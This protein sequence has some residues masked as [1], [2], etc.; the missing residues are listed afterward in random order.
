MLPIILFG[1]KETLPIVGEGEKTEDSPFQLCQK[2]VDALLTLKRSKYDDGAT[3]MA[4]SL[5]MDREFNNLK[6]IFSQFVGINVADFSHCMVWKKTKAMVWKDDIV[7][8]IDS[9]EW[10]T[11]LS[12]D[13]SAHYVVLYGAA[14]NIVNSCVFVA[15]QSS[16]DISE[17]DK[18]CLEFFKKFDFSEQ[19]HST[20]P[21][22]DSMKHYLRFALIFPAIEYQVQREEWK[23][24][25]EER[26]KAEQNLPKR[27][28]D[29]LKDLEVACQDGLKDLEVACQDE[30]EKLKMCE[31]KKQILTLLE[32][33]NE[34][35]KWRTTQEILTLAESLDEWQKLRT[36]QEILTLLQSLDK[37][38]EFWTTW[39]NKEKTL[40]NDWK[41]TYKLKWN[42]LSASS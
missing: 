7:T 38:K 5:V 10:S 17:D 6:T 27:W 34:W 29:G 1:A 21:T 11:E 25:K 39:E 32:R 30:A 8:Q 3:K 9:F 31:T 42:G 28:Q 22:V 4:Q 26:A 36:T 37:C 35:K 33:I 16:A 24:F 41:K 23:K 12:T 14:E 13:K 40:Q 19:S 20:L 18:K 2:S 15:H